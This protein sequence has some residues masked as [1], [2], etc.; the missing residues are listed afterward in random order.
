MGPVFIRK[1]LKAFPG[2]ATPA[3]H[4]M[5]ARISSHL[6]TRPSR[7]LRITAIS[8]PSSHGSSDPP[9]FTWIFHHFD[10]LLFY[11]FSA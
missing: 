3:R 1:L 7:A 9:G 2:E 4:G 11:Q 6:R 5:D 10:L 8:H